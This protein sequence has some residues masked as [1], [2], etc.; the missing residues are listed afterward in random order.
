MPLLK[1]IKAANRLEYCA[2]LLT[3]LMAFYLTIPEMSSDY[4]M[5][6]ETM[7]EKRK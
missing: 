2:S 7:S 5:L 4:R 6:M 1:I 3:V